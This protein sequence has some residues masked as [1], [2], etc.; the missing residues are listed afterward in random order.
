MPNYVCKVQV[1]GLFH[2]YGID[3]SFRPG[4]NV[5]YGRNGSGKTT[6]LHILA[7]VLNESY[8]RFAELPFDRIEVTTTENGTL[9]IRRGRGHGAKLVVEQDG[10]LVIDESIEEIR[11][12]D[13]L[14]STLERSDRSRTVSTPSHAYFPAFRTAIEAWAESSSEESRPPYPS[15]LSWR[16]ANGMDRTR[17]RRRD[18]R[19]TAFARRLFGPFVPTI[20]YPSPLE[21]QEELSAKARVQA[22]DVA[23][24]SQRILSDAFIGAIGAL[25]QPK[26][27]EE[28]TDPETILTQIRALLEELDQVD[29]AGGSQPAADHANDL[30]PHI[31]EMLPM[32]NSEK[33]SDTAARVLLVFKESLE[34]QIELRRQAFATIS[35]YIEAVNEFLEQ[36]QLT[37]SR[38]RFQA[39]LEFDKGGTKPLN[40]LSSGERQIVT[41]LYAA[42]YLSQRGNVVLIDEPEISLHVDWQ[43]R[44]L[45][46]MAEQLGERQ[47]IVCTH[48]P[49]IGADYEEAIQEMETIPETDLSPEPDEEA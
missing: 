28:Q 11:R 39:V 37:L 7:N 46:K 40:V 36:K 2:R 48:S 41:M 1:H 33:L 24:H 32:L 19:M 26:T 29:L 16:A 23:S 13:Y 27:P 49:E 25:P 3:V 18:L 20:D 31:R 47:V 5:L 34:R 15:Y 43:R 8:E 35:K 9:R 17:L 45:P 42:T 38:D 22:Y 4:I 30:Y 12:R 14:G 44:L 6:L 21:I 10:K